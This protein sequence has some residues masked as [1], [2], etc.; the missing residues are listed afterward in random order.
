MI[1]LD[2]ARQALDME[3]IL[4]GKRIFMVAANI[5]PTGLDQLVM[6]GEP[7]EPV[8]EPAVLP[9]DATMPQPQDMTMEPV[10]A[11]APARNGRGQ[12]AG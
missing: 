8:P 11:G 2:E 9:P 5:V 7:P 4:G 3:P 6:A 12:P 1:D 10:A